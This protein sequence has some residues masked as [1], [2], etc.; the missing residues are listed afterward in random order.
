MVGIYNRRIFVVVVLVCLVICSPLQVW[1][2]SS[3]HSSSTPLVSL[4]GIEKTLADY[5]G[6]KVVVHFFAT[7]CHPCQEEM[8]YIVSFSN[9][10]KEN[11]AV[12]VPIHLTKMDSDL[13]QL[14]SFLT[15]YEADFDPWLDEK[16]EMMQQY[17]V[18]GIP[19]TLFIDENGVVEQR[20]NGMLPQ[21]EAESYIESIKKKS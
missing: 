9:Q 16:G 13:G 1:A 18:V 8:P 12:F 6:K 2:G 3:S 5:K 17:H 7:W 15:H 10:L 20:M 21:H 14:Q 4:A 19:T 11:G